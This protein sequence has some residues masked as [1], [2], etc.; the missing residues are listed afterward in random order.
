MDEALERKHLA[1]VEQHI[2]QA[3][4]YILRQ[5]QLINKLERGGHD[6]RSA[7][8]MLEALERCLEAF[9]QHR[10]MIVKRLKD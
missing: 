7:V 3:K 8:S 6:T 10:K 5:Q 9:K 4:Q 2:A 1:Q